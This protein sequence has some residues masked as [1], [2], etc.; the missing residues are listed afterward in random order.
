[1]RQK[2][3]DEEV[4][5]EE[6]SK[7]FREVTNAPSRRRETTLIWMNLSISIPVE[8]TRYN[9]FSENVA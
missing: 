4:V 3:D 1:M 7:V 6:I 8:M 5:D 9:I 2:R